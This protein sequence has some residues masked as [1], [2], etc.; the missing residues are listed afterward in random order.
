MLTKV[1]SGLIVWTPPETS[2]ADKHL[3]AA[4]LNAKVKL[5]LSA[6]HH[7]HMALFGFS[8]V[9]SRVD[10]SVFLRSIV[11]VSHH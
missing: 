8:S 1:Q 9:V 5:F 4:G 7:K 3:A 6:F 2:N 11:V 10:I